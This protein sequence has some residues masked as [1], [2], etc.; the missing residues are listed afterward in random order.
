MKGF[1]FLV[2]L[3]LL[4][5]PLIGAEGITADQAVQ[6]ALASNL[7]LKSA[8]K[9]LEIRERDKEWSFQRFFPTITAGAGWLRWNDVT[10]QERLVNITPQFGPSGLE[11][12]A[13]TVFT[14]DP[15][16]IGAE[17]NVQFTL[18]LTTFA[19]IR[20]TLAEWDAGRLDF[21]AARQRLAGSTRKTFYQI[22]G[23]LQTRQLIDAQVANAEARLSQVQA[24][25]RAGT[26]PELT[27]L[28][29]QVEVENRHGDRREIDLRIDQALYGFSQLLG[30]APTKD[31]ELSGDIDPT[32]PQADLSG[33]ALAD[34]YIDRRFDLRGLDAQDRALQA[35]AAEVD[36][37]AYPQIVLGYSAD[38]SVNN[39]W[40]TNVL[41]GSNW[42][43]VN[44][45]VTV[46]L[47]WKL[48]TLLPGSSY[49]TQRAD[50]ASARQGLQDSRHQLAD[51]ARAEVIGL[52]EQI[53]SST[54]ALA[55]L[56]R[57]VE[58]AE[59]AETLA[60]AAFRSGVRSLLEVQDA[61]LQ[62]QAAQLA[63]LQEKIKLA[64]ALIDLEIAL[65]TPLEEINGS[66]H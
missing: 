43:Q 21:E 25:Y 57:N 17:I 18:S 37:E 66:S 34:R 24:G 63:L 46:Q 55:G 40:H 10:S 28:Q 59:R 27:V 53:G 6:E 30:R 13:P 61:D 54:S 51:A 14:P 44:G 38:P 26:M 23:L 3:S 50:L 19:A 52:V 1:V 2:F 48:D 58:A 49:W 12:L 7:G 47:Q 56:Q 9:K 20:Q 5:P 41:D 64:G 65:N 8:A 29:S 45:A 31:I 32:P 42:M 4:A 15:Q 39:P 16:N 22:L 35:Q 60:Q 62:A 11:G 33:P 36:S